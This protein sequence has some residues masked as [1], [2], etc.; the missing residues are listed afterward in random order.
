MY[1]DVKG[2]K[3][4]ISSSTSLSLAFLK[5]DIT[6]FSDLTLSSLSLIAFTILDVPLS[7]ALIIA[8]SSESVVTEA[9]LSALFL[10]IY[11]LYADW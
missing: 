10:L 4:I 3:L 5:A 11:L 8:V 6:L 2:F 7:I 1:H 9:I